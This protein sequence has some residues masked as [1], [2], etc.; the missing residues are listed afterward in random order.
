M[1]IDRRFAVN[2]SL[3]AVLGLVSYAVV[4]YLWN[5]IPL[6]PLTQWLIYELAGTN[7]FKPVISTQDI[8]VNQALSLPLAALLCLL[9]PRRLLLFTLA[10]LLEAFVWSLF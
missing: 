1:A 2:L 6:N 9:R 3:A 8:L 7:L 4:A 10:A 5:F